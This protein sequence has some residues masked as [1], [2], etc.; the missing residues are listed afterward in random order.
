MRGEKK[1]GIVV[2]PNYRIAQQQHD[3]SVRMRLA[4]VA[5]YIYS[6]TRWRTSLA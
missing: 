4:P 2:F 5:I 3:H 6:R 1:S